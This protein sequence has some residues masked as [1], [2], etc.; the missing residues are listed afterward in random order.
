MHHAM[1]SYVRTSPPL[2]PYTRPP[3]V[4]DPP[5]WLPPTSYVV[6]NIPGTIPARAT[7][8]RPHGRLSRL[9]LPQ[10]TPTVAASRSMVGA[11][12]V[13]V[14]SSATVATSIVPLIVIVEPEATCTPSTLR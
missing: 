7:T 1:P 8:L 13:T 2:R 10:F 11:S 6:T 4:D 5:I 12:L 14:T 3:R 9:P